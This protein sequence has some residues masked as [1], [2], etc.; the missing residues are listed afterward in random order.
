MQ[1]LQ[2]S[3]IKKDEC[4]TLNE[5]EKFDLTIQVMNLKVILK[6]DK[7][8]EL[9]KH[10]LGTQ[11][12]HL[13]KLKKNKEFLLKAGI[14]EDD[15]TRELKMKQEEEF[16][17]RTEEKVQKLLKDGNVE[18]F[19]FLQEP[20]TVKI[21]EIQNSQPMLALENSAPALALTM[22]TERHSEDATDV[23]EPPPCPVHLMR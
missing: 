7:C 22:E 8:P 1:P 4:G 12:V 15:S 2:I 9:S 13:H 18:L 23:K 6:Q 20:S 5:E 16:Q 11:F 10:R 21:E 19:S 3:L 17:K 14:W